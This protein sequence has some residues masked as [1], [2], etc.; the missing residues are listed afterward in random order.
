LLKLPP[1]TNVGR[2]TMELQWSSRK[3]P[4]LMKVERGRG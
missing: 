2:R 3:G 1:R 4:I